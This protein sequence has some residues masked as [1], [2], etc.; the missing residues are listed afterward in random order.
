[1]RGRSHSRRNYRRFTAN[2]R[3]NHGA[4]GDCTERRPPAGI[5]A[6]HRIVSYRRILIPF[7]AVA[8]L[9]VAAGTAAPPASAAQAPCWKVLLNDW[10]DGTIDGSYPVHCYREA[11]RNLPDDVDAYTEARE[12][13][14]RALLAAIRRSGGTLQ[15]DDIVPPEAG[16]GSGRDAANGGNGRPGADDEDDDVTAAPNSGDDDGLI[17]FFR[18]SNADEI[19]LP[20]LLL[21]GLAVLLLAAASAGFVARRLQ[22]RR[23]RPMTARGAPPAPPEA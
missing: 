8:A 2:L 12:D 22:A 4:G 11:I 6:A 10:Y 23:L 17:G 21:A 20:L 13:I 16:P 3:Q 18:P 5:G 9:S 7:L 1:M 14:Q 15:D 19:P